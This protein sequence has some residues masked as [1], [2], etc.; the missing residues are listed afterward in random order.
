MTGSRETT[1]KERDDG[2]RDK[3]CDGNACHIDEAT[4]REVGN[5]VSSTSCLPVSLLRAL[6]PISTAI[7]CL[8]FLCLCIHLFFSS[9]LP[10]LHC[11]YSSLYVSAL[12]TMDTIHLSALSLSLSSL[13]LSKLFT[14]R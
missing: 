8:V 4:P 3:S 6:T 11:D 9:N 2:S 5:G 7:I 14:V 1:V 13:I 12:S 10:L